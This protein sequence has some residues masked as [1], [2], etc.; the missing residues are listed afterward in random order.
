MYCKCNIH[1]VFLRESE[2]ESVGLFVVATEE[3]LAEFIR[4]T[5]PPALGEILNGAPF[6]LV[7]TVVSLIFMKGTYWF[8]ECCRRLQVISQTC[9]DVMMLG[10]Q[11]FRKFGAALQVPANAVGGKYLQL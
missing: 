4:V 5:R 3:V 11:G 1:G 7:H 9:E 6:F 10:K 2:S 8:M